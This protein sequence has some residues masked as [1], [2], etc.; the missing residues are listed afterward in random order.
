LAG[1]IPVR[2]AAPETLT[3][4]KSAIQSVPLDGQAVI[5][6]VEVACTGIG[7]TRNDPKWSAWPVRVEFSNAQHAYETDAAVALVNA[8][9]K[10]VLTASCEGPWLLLKPGPGAYTV[11][12]RLSDS[13]AKPRSARFQT[14]A[15]GQIRVVIEFP[16]A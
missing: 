1:A 10:T 3:G 6:G 16:D 5:G 7:E 14:P 13:P 15:H 12:A 8:K 2:A 9:G 11:F 4:D